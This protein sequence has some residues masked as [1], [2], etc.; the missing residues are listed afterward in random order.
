[1]QEQIERDL[2]AAML[3]GDKNKVEILKGLKSALQYEAVGLKSEDR[4]LNDEQIQKVLAREAKKRQ[5]TA[6]IY[7]N[8]NETERADKELAEKEVIDKYLPEKLSEE[9]IAQAVSEEIKKTGA[10]TAADMGKVIGAVRSRLGA[11]ADGSTIARLT[12]EML[13]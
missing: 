4:T 12:K 1:V 13:S 2:K 11:G 7:K 5:E 10:A 8:A 6:E 3:S 9:E